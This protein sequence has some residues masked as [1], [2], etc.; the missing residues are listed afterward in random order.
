[1]VGALFLFAGVNG[2]SQVPFSPVPNSTLN[3]KGEL[4]VIGNSI[5]GLNETIDG[6]TYTPNDDFNG[7][8]GN[9]QRTFGYIDIDNDPSTFSSSS[10]DFNISSN[11]GKIAYAGLYWAATYYVDR[12]PAD[13]TFAQYDDL[14]IP[15]NR[16]DF[17]TLK[18]KPPGTNSYID[19]LSSSTQVI[20]DGYRNTNTNPDNTAV[21]DIPYVC[22]TDVTSIL[23]DLENPSG[24]YTIANM[25]ASTGLATTNSNGISGGWMLVIVYED[26]TL[27]QK[28]ISTENGYLNIIPSDL[29]TSF[30]Y[31]GFMTPPAPLPINARYAIASLE[32]DLNFDGDNLLITNVGGI[33]QNLFTAPANSANNFFD[34]SISV[35]G[36][37]STS[38]TPASQNTL[39]FD[40]D[41]FDI[42]NPNNTLIGNNQT[43]AEFSLRSRGDAYNVFFNSFQVEVIEP[44]L[45]VIERV[46]D[47]NQ[48]DITGGSVDFADELFYE[49]TIQNKGNEDIINTSIKNILPKNVDFRVGS[50]SV[51]NPGITVIHDDI[52]QEV[53]ITINDALLANNGDVLTVR[54]GVTVVTTCA[55][56]RDACSNEIDNV[57]TFSYTGAVSGISIT[58]KESI[59]EQDVCGFDVVGGPNI[60]IRE[61][62]CFNET[63]PAFICTGSTTL[64]AGA[65]FTNYSW[66]NI[67]NPGVVIGTNQSIDVTVAG[68]YTVTKTGAVDCLDGL[69]TFVVDAFNNIVNP[70]VDIVNS[71]GSNPNVSGGIRTCPITGEP[72]PEIFF[73]GAGTTLNID[74]GFTTAASIFWERLDPAACPT[75]IRDENCPTF[76]SGCEGDWVQVGTGTNF[77]VSQAGEY[78]INA[79]FDNNCT[80][81]F[82]FNVFQNNFDPNLV[83]LQDII[84]G[85]PG[86]LRVQNSSNQYEYQL[87]TPITNTIIGYQISPEF[88]GLTEVGTY[89]L[90]ARQATGIPTACIFEGNVFL[91]DR[92]SDVVVEPVSPICPEDLGL[93]NITVLNAE[94][95][96]TYIINST[97]DNFTQIEGPTTAS[98]HV[99]T[100]LYPGTYDVEVLSYDGNCTENYTID[101]L[102]ASNTSVIASL[103]KDLSCNPDYNPDPTIPEYDPN[104]NIALIN[105]DIIGGSG[106]YTFSTIE[107]FSSMINP[108]STNGNT[109]SFRFGQA[110]TYQIYVQDLEAGCTL[111]TNPV[112]VSPYEA[113]Q[114]VIDITN[115][116]CSDG[117][118]AAITATVISGAAPYSYLLDGIEV[119]GATDQT[120]F[121][122]NNVDPGM[123]HI[124]EVQD[125]F[126][127]SITTQADIL[128]PAPI[129]ADF[130]LARELSC[131]P[132]SED[133]IVEIFNI[134]GGTG[135]YEW[136]FDQAGTF[137]PVVSSP[138]AISIAVAGTHP[139]F[140]RDSNGCT[141]TFDVIVPEL[142]ELYL[143]AV[144][145]NPESCPGSS[146]G[147]ILAYINTNQ[148]TNVFDYEVTEDNTG[149]IITIG[150]SV[151]NPI[152]VSN[153]AAGTYTIR[154]V[155]SNTYCDDIITVFIAEP[156]PIT[157]D[158]TVTQPTSSQGGEILVNAT[159]GTPPYAYAIDS[160]GPVTD[161]VFTD[162]VPGIYTVVTTDSYGC[163]F[164][165]D[166]EIVTPVEDLSVELNLDNSSVVCFG[167]NTASI[168]ATVTGGSGIYS[169]TLTGTDYLGSQVSIGAQGNS[170]FGNLF[171]GDYVYTVESNGL[172]SESVAFTVT[173]PLE[174]LVTATSTDTSCNSNQDGAIRINVTGGTAPYFFSLYN[175]GNAVF[176][177]IEDDS[178]GIAGE[179][180]F[181][182]LAAGVY[183]VAVE[184]DNGCPFEISDIIINEP[185]PIALDLTVT[186]ITNDADGVIE[187][188][189]TGGTSPY[190]Y[191]LKEAETGSVISTQ[192]NTIFTIGTPGDYIVSVVDNSNCTT[193]QLVI[194]ESTEQNPLL[195]YADEI[196]FCAITGQVYP[197]ITIEDA[198]G[199]AIDLPFSGV[200]SIVWQQLNDINC[201]IELENN[202]PTTDSSCTSGWF[203]LST[204]LNCNIT[205]AGE[206]RVVIEFINKSVD[207]I[208]TYYFKVEKNVSTDTVPE[209]SMFPNPS[210]DK[211]SF[212]TDVENVVVYNMMGKI[213]LEASQNSFSISALTK[214]VYFVQVVTKEGKEEVIKLMKE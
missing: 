195:D 34:S 108:V 170:F 60:L 107:D 160:G 138:T 202:C 86:T 188:I 186:P 133:A 207:T 38:R 153:L 169:Y 29:D 163:T 114:M 211:V 59:L 116:I 89:T 122:F 105:V 165:T 161:A 99:F 103:I 63:Q 93:V 26:N 82:Y 15:D 30:T 175:N 40:V 174:F 139:I 87:I 156:I 201:D 58:G 45:T 115:P 32:G 144:V 200:A 27:T 25:R 184:D 101:I 206:Y 81:P 137:T 130:A 142:I 47:V 162:L 64:T 84:C 79:T 14:P 179:Q 125:T 192:A 62:I 111:Q 196:I 90:Y 173:Q 118:D 182:G 8:I 52:N 185:T 168:N 61:D 44:E 69:E 110:G 12:N 57:V 198:N 109:Y 172:L 85:N 112:V 209:L 96:Y 31:S 199:E 149:A 121:T 35:D 21:I 71:L 191:I 39:G 159:G 97:T 53:N 171:A 132:G 95:N 24:T 187:I 134:T 74:S 43:S 92:I 56:L 11:C 210:N 176:T 117:D 128:V 50:V 17:R 9:N 51:S 102:P 28:Y 203:D 126:G 6:T 80:V 119:S 141:I 75:V 42:P 54:F 167:L 124:I 205:D 16:P 5:V 164:E 145:A 65:G 193:D 135:N 154:A 208:Q 146:D 3:I 67:S 18:I 177:F 158:V 189:A 113:L 68:T 143:D 120:T 20:Y 212:N 104:E 37:Y 4:K 83:V 48:V 41:I 140:V 77:T 70:V 214:G 147:E 23:K 88:T 194:V 7:T 166:V 73:C 1:M 178:D 148:S 76:D 131:I 129:V 204:S 33:K 46:L 49:L 213:V 91:E 72:L 10:A 19:I 155:D 13:N 157:V 94:I 98:E 55:D 181:E 150:S 197:T 180:T 183:R 152:V 100:G 2:Y 151:S 136:S 123:S 22:Y 78:R 36:A 106:N 127:C 190:T 66:E